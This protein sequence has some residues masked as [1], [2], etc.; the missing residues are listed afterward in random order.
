MGVCFKDCD[1]DK[2]SSGAGD[3]DDLKIN[4]QEV[5]TGQCNLWACLGMLKKCVLNM[6]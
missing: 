2:E 1:Q 5:S 6:V 4:H 3:Y